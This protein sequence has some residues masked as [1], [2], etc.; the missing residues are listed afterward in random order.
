MLGGVCFILPAALMVTALAWAYVRFGAVP[1]VA[2][3][4]VNVAA[5]ALM[6]VV[7]AQLAKAAL[8]DVPTTLIALGGAALLIRFKVNTTWLVAGGALLGAIL[9]VA[10]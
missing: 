2:G 1:G 3:D 6:A 9:R 5:L 4:G 8:V 7:T 10:Q